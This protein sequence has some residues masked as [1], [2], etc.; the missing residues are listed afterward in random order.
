MSATEDSSIGSASGAEK[1]YPGREVTTTSKASSSRPLWAA[2]SRR[3]APSMGSR[4]A[5]RTLLRDGCDRR[6][7]VDAEGDLGSGWH[8]A[9]GAREQRQFVVD[10]HACDVHAAV[11]RQLGRDAPAGPLSGERAAAAVRAELP[12]GEAS[13]AAPLA[14]A[15]GEAA[16]LVD[17]SAA[18]A[19]APPWR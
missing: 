11:A 9:F 18:T 3:R 5:S 8:G 6:S 12:S 2:G 7:V 10:P 19:A 4:R 17:S 1:P 15:H 13:V 14:T 16:Q